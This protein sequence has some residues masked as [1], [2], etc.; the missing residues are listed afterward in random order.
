MNLQDYCDSYQAKKIRDFLQG[1]CLRA[2]TGLG[3]VESAYPGVRVVMLRGLDIWF[4]I[5]INN[6]RH[7]IWSLDAASVPLLVQDTTRRRL[8]VLV[9]TRDVDT[10]YQMMSFMQMIDP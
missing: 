2:D 5:W 8:R 6:I 3:V 7:S 9:E 10:V 1:L 4:E